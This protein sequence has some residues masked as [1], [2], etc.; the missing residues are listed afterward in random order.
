MAVEPLIL[1][2]FIGATL[3]LVA[4]PGP[5]VSL[6]ISETLTYGWRQGI[7]VAFGA[8]TVGFVFLAFYVLGAAPLMMG[9]PGWSFDVL[10]YVGAA[11]LLYLAYDIIT[12][13]NASDDHVIDMVSTPLAAYKKAIAVTST[14]PKTV[15][16]F[17]AFFPQFLNKS[18]PFLPQMVILSLAFMVVSVASDCMWVFT[19]N[20]ARTWLAEK[21]GR[22]L[23]KRISGSTLAAGALLLLAINP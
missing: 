14:S 18:Q 17:A 9:L 8:G 1:L 15:L 6:M 19:A 4:T 5:V 11:F 2:M 23:I 22:K 3:A 21:G 10:R 7:A 20:K 12:T 16:F 13:A